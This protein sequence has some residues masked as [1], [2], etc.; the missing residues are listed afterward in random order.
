VASTQKQAKRA[1]RTKMK[2]KQARAIRNNAPRKA[3]VESIEF[4]QSAIDLFKRMK[5]AE[6]ISRVE[7]HTTLL[8]DPGM[9]KVGSLENAVDMQIV[10]LK[11]YGAKF[12]EDRPDDW[13][14]D[15]AFLEDYAN[16]SRIVGKEELIDAWKEAHSF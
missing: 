13:M 15:A 16:A 11:A 9:S 12:S 6:A 1:K 10:F 5:D 7:M 2:A 4:S 14:E 8:S 3:T